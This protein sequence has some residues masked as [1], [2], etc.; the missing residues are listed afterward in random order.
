MCVH[1][2]CLYAH[3]LYT[4]HMYPCVIGEI[5]ILLVVWNM[6]FH[7]LGIIIPTY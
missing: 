4:S 6:C 2:M 3:C 5:L 1:T 7:I